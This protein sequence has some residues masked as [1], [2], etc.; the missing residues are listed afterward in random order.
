MRRRI[1]PLSPVLSCSLL[2][3]LESLPLCCCVI[4]KEA[5]A[6]EEEAEAAEGNRC[7]NSEPIVVLAVEYIARIGRRV[8]VCL[9]IYQ[10]R[11]SLLE[12]LHHMK[13]VVCIDIYVYKLE[14]VAAGASVVDTKHPHFGGNGN[15]DRYTNG[16][17]EAF[18]ELR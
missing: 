3:L 1:R 8:F 15:L 9:R 16:W 10:Q 12:L 5:A 6:A 11:V 14:K 4:P 13:V 18:H 2:L 17:I 7:R